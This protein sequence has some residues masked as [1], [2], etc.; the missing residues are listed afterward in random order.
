MSTVTNGET[1][2]V[3]YSPGQQWVAASSSLALEGRICKKPSNPNIPPF[4]NGST[5][6]FWHTHDPTMIKDQDGLFQVYFTDYNIPTSIS[7]DRKTFYGNGTAFLN[8]LPWTRNYTHSKDRCNYADFKSKDS[9]AT[10]DCI[11]CPDAHYVNGKY[12][13]YYSASSFGS[14]VSGMYLATSLTG[15]S[16]DWTN[17]GEV[18]NSAA[19]SWNAI[20]PSLLVDDDGTWYMSF[21]SWFS[22]IWQYTLNSTGFVKDGAQPVHLA[23]GSDHG[24]RWNGIEGS[25]LWKN[26]KEHK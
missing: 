24:T 6:G 9:N 14:K 16:D 22:G 26:G 13:M 23:D 8:G 11:W 21:G 20:D 18:F 4:R 1:L 3:Y 5:L 10:E 17:Q 12:Y 15:R 2:S 25:C 19:F 7:S